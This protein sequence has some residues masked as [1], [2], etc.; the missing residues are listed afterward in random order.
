MKKCV[1][2]AWGEYKCNNFQIENFEKNGN[3]QSCSK[4][5]SNGYVCP[6]GYE[7]IN[8]NNCMRNYCNEND[9]NVC[10]KKKD[11]CIVKERELIQ[12]AIEMKDQCGNYVPHL[13]ALIGSCSSF[14]GECPEGTELDGNQV[15]SRNVCTMED[16][17][18]CCKINGVYVM[19]VL[20]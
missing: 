5:E 13:K 15:C 7:V 16:V 12:K 19:M 8:D 18:T 4:F 11:K 17:N 3:L 2:E 9:K 6:Q 20:R 14:D 10:C 1:D